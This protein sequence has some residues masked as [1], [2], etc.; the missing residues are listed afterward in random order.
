M[1]TDP[2]GLMGLHQNRSKFP[3]SNFSPCSFPIALVPYVEKSPL[4]TL[5]QN[6]YITVTAV[7]PTP[8]LTRIRTDDI[9]SKL[10]RIV[11]GSRVATGQAMGSTRLIPTVRSQALKNK[12]KQ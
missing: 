6:I 3:K 8:E 10:A 7:R 2:N 4:E 1:H 11:I 12:H 5:R 9:Y